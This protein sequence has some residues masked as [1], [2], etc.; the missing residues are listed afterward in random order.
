MG[1]PR[2]LGGNLSPSSS[3]RTTAAGHLLAPSDQDAVGGEGFNLDTDARHLA[4][5]ASLTNGTCSALSTLKSAC[6]H[7]HQ[8]A[9]APCGKG[10]TVF[11]C[12]DWWTEEGPGVKKSFSIVSY[13][14]RST[15]AKRCLVKT[16]SD[17]EDEFNLS[18]K[19]EDCSSNKEEDNWSFSALNLGDC[20]PTALATSNSALQK[21]CSQVC[22]ILPLIA[23][24][25]LLLAVQ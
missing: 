14:S 19:N 25:L 15:S 17:K 1:T 12:H 10:A 6:V 11:S 24:R 2:Q 23:A 18:L 20:A 4:D 13:K 3:A 16:L 8:M 9:I 7:S 22:S 5:L 21:A